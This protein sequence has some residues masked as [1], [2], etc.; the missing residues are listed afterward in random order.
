MIDGR[1]VV[2]SHGDQRLPV[3]ARQLQP[4]RRIGARLHEDPANLLR[5]VGDAARLV[6]LAG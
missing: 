2:E 1:I 4:D 6:A 5:I 3:V